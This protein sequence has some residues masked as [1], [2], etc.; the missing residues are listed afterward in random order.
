MEKGKRKV[1]EIYKHIARGSLLLFQEMCK[2]SGE[3]LALCIP[4][5]DGV[6]MANMTPH[7]STGGNLCISILFRIGIYLS[8][9]LVYFASM[10]T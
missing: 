5:D 6:L 7:L 9:C 1:G 4:R 10:H 3:V 8:E 2:R